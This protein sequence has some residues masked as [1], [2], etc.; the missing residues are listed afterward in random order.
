MSARILETTVDELRPSTP[1]T[2]FL[3][4]PRAGEKTL[5]WAEEIAGL[6]LRHGGGNRRLAVDRCD[7]EPAA[8]PDRARHRARR[9][10]AGDRAGA[11]DQDA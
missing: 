3:A 11:H 10:A 6:V 8:A 5:Q 4:G 9:R 7:P 1:F 2:Y